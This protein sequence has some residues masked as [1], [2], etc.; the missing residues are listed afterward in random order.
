MDIFLLLLMATGAAFVQRAAGFGFGIF[1]MTLLPYLMP[2]YGEATTLS[3]MLALCSSIIITFRKYKYLRWKKLLPIITVFFIVSYFA[4]RIVG[5]IDDHILKKVL[6]IALIAASAWF[7]F[8]SNKIK[9]KPTLSTQVS[10]GTLS[11][12]MGGLFGMQGPPA[13]IYFISAAP[14]KDEYIAMAQ[15][16]FLIGNVI[17]TVYRATCGFLTHTVFIDWAICLPAVAFGTA[18]GALVFN[19]MSMRKLKFVIYIYMA[20]TGVIALIS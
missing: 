20:L 12:F 5:N 3:G 18:L 4:V 13:V 7:L 17:M 15:M 10:M 19:R 2:T 6:G 16:Y 11:G 1:I 8:F 9:M 14:T